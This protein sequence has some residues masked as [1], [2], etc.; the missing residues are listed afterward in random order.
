MTQFLG[1][2]HN[3]IDSKGRV[4]IPAPFRSLLKTDPNS[5]AVT[6]VLRPSHK[7]A[8]IEG[9]PVAE[10]DKLATPLERL[11][12]FS[13]EHDDFALALFA[14]AQSMESDKEGRIVLPDSFITHAN[15]TDTVTFMGAGR[16]FQIWTPAAAVA[17]RV[18]ALRGSVQKTLPGPPA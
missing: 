10:F 2:H 1:T 13:D 5:M 3:K 16:S 15:L 14:E 7:F 6:V 12:L 18:A 9:W 17:R 4:S 11:D 8:C